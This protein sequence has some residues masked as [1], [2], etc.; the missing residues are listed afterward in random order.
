LKAQINVIWTM[1]IPPSILY[2]P[3]YS[4]FF[5]CVYGF[6]LISFKYS[7]DE[8]VQSNRASITRRYA[9]GL[10]VLWV[11]N[12]SGGKVLSE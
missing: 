7:F 12:G 10:H 5:G 11:W 8:T 1:I 6:V 9:S 4:I 3:L 2:V